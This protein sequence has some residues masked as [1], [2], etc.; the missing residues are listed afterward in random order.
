MVAVTA[1]TAILSLSLCACGTNPNNQ[2]ASDNSNSS[3]STQAENNYDPEVESIDYSTER[4]NIKYEYVEKANSELTKSDNALL[5][6][7][8]FTNEQDEPSPAISPF[9]IEFYQNGVE[10]SDSPSYSSS[11]GDQYELL[12]A[13]S[14][15][16]M[17]GSTI[18]FGQ[19]VVPKD[20][21]PITIT[22]KPNGYF[23][24]NEYQTME[25]AIDSL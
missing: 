3:S 12:R 21:S 25:V 22:I 11:G 17:K 6:V 23:S 24:D 1:C 19:L 2:S 5:F 9:I 8:D 4:G 14:D 13:S 10:L 20:D 18:Q 7:F 15:S 16:V